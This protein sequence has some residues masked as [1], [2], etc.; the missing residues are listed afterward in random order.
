VLTTYGISPVTPLVDEARAFHAEQKEETDSV[1]LGPGQLRD[2]EGRVRW[3]SSFDDKTDDEIDELLDEDQ[4]L[5]LFAWRDSLPAKYSY[6]LEGAAS[7]TPGK[8]FR[9][10]LTKIEGSEM[11]FEVLKEDE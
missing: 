7:L 2:K 11:T 9:C 6:N 4:A 5:R 3:C 8:H 10:T 1:R